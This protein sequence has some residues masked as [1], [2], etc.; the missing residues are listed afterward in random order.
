MS[1]RERLFV[2][3]AALALSGCNCFV[4]VEEC[5]G[6]KCLARPDGG[7]KDAGTDGGK[8]DAGIAD[9][10]A[11]VVTCAIWDGGGVGK[12][13]AITGYVAEGKTCRGECVLYPIV[14]P[15]VFPTLAECVSCGCD[16]AKLSSKPVQ[17]FNATAFCD[18]VNV[19]TS[20]PGPLADVFGAPDS[21]FDGG[22]VATGAVDFRC[23]IG[24]PG[25]LGDAGVARACAATLTPGVTDVNCLVLIQ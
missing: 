20:Q 17:T 18:E 22:C 2:L 16:A 24:G 5:V 4:P 25:T 14:T 13:A 9:G 21:G 23:R 15:G 1:S 3:A 8:A 7:A 19:T 11:S 12:C 6:K 10:G